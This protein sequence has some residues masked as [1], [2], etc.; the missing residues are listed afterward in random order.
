[1]ASKTDILVRSEKGEQEIKTQANKLPIKHRSVLI[2]IDGKSSEET[3]QSKL[4][5]MFDGK[6]ILSDLE[7]HGFITRNVAPKQPLPEKAVSVPST[8]KH[9][10]SMLMNIVSKVK[11]MTEEFEKK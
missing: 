3:L 9:G 8:G 4:S 1:M 2:M 7:L 6:S 5:G 11:E 10:E